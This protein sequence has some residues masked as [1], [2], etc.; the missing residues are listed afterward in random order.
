MTDQEAIEWLHGR[1][2]LGEKKDPDAMR[3]LMALL[4]D[5]QDRLAFV[6]I[7]GTNGKGSVA[8]MLASI[9]REAGIRTGL[10]V[11]PF[12]EEFGERI[13]VD[14]APL[15]AGVLGEAAEQARA[16]A[17]QLEK[18]GVYATEFE[19]VT[20]VG[21]LCFLQQ[22]CELVC[23][24]AG[25]G[26]GRDATNVIRSTKVACLT[27]IGLDHTE[28]LGGTVEAIAEEKCG[29][30][31]PG[32]VAVSYPGQRPGAAA[33][34]ARRCKELGVPLRLP[35]PQDVKLLWETLREN[36]VD[37]GGYAV[38]LRLHGSHQAAN[39]AVAI[40]A[41]LGLCDQGYD[42]PDEAILAG[43]EQASLPARAEVLSLH[44]PVLLDGA[45]NPDSAAALAALLKGTK[46]PPITGVLGMLKGKD[47]QAVLK[48]L[49][50]CFDQVYTAAPD[51]PRAVSADLLAAA[52]SEHFP[53]VEACGSLAQ[54][55]ALAQK[56][57]RGFC[58][59]GSFYLA[60]EARRLLC[61]EGKLSG[62]LDSL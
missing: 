5:P 48:A 6:H 37:Y 41:A 45:H 59:C 40:E 1:R 34:I 23:L 42:I 22:G 44:P 2:R 55:L 15:P 12:V 7:A 16:A 26:G 36:H 25:L 57:G 19:L 30:L 33:V 38:R 13:T 35:E 50:G 46:T 47:A 51:T 3:R 53:R 4:G 21:F 43:L 32:C 8:A 60:G 29:I 14:G 18:E 39:C 56:R 27:R 58:V 11:S 62:G 61:G 31:K 49:E 28:L 17:G 20:A 54:A 24:E 52:A 10:F 9:L